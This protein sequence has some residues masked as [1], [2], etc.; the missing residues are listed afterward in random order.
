MKTLRS[1]SFVASLL[2]AAVIATGPF[3]WATT[4]ASAQENAVAPA[5]SET[6]KKKDADQPEPAPSAPSPEK[7]EDKKPAP[8]AA[9]SEPPL[10]SLGDD[11]AD[12]TDKVQEKSQES[13]PKTEDEDEAPAKKVH[14]KPHA[15]VAIEVDDES[16][17]TD[18][19]GAWGYQAPRGSRVRVLDDNHVAKGVTVKGDAVAVM[20]DLSVEGEVGR[21]AVSVLGDNHINGVVHRNVVGI[22]GD[23]TLG[24]NA[25]VEGNV[26]SV[27]GEVH[28]DP[29]A[30]VR[31]QVKEQD[32]DEEFVPARAWWNKTLRIGRPLAIGAH[33]G[34]LWAL[35]AISLGFYALLG[36]VFP[37]TI[38][39][40]G[41]K[42]VLQPGLTLL[43]A[44][45][46]VL[47]LPL[48]FVLLCITLIGIPI[49]LLL[50]P[51]GV[52][53]GA[54]FGKASIY[55]LV[56]RKL[57][58]DRFHPAVT[59]LLGALIFV[60]L[61]LV[62]VLGLLLSLL[63]AFLGF[64]CVILTL[65]SPAPK[66][67]AAM[68][69]SVATP[70]AGLPETPMAAAMPAS[71]PVLTPAP[72]PEPVAPPAPVPPVLPAAVT[73]P[74]FS[75]T[76]L[77]RAGF[78]IRL[79]AALLDVILIGMGIGIFEAIFHALGFHPGEA[80]P[81]WVVLYS[82]VMWA[83]RGTTIG[84]AVCGLRLVRLDDRP[85]DWGVA[86]VRAIGGFLSLAVA[87]IGFIWVA[88]DDER[89][90]WHDKIAGTTIVRVPRGTALL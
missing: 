41:D 82:V 50:L 46:S 83:T 73:P 75:A 90:S 58:H 76:L 69:A 3:W 2:V 66:P 31:G 16:D 52:I 53:F 8:A 13:A 61:Y 33:L 68:P 6:E 11:N 22:L 89:Q 40:C 34:W 62:P 78:W 14:K 67:V 32:V 24:P 10:R 15:S 57:F 47:A 65:F 71:A 84:G 63:A 45:L 28:R 74:R 42:L 20:G 23:I 70:V 38:R 85:V 81:F 19:R 55:G 30:V 17:S 39:K 48:L 29:A 72:T 12:A 37:A 35:T 1:L 21:D 86:I 27:S 54:F 26:I 49:A 80:F 9:V 7:E 44:V 77:P 51:V 64:G 25:R 4:R 5:A 43:A 56:G 59:V 87:G 36:L 18:L 60:V 79:A 88:F